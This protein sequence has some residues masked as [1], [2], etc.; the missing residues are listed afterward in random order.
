ML[1][2]PRQA[3]EWRQELVREL[4]ASVRGGVPIIPCIAPPKCDALMCERVCKAGPPPCPPPEE[5]P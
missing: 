2:Y 3:S 1:K 4:L 5:R